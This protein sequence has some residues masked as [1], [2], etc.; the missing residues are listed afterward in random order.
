MGS[1][2]YVVLPRK[3][4]HNSTEHLSL[5]QSLHHGCMVWTGLF[6]QFFFCLSWSLRV[7]KTTVQLTLSSSTQQ[8]HS[9]IGL[10]FRIPQC[11]IPGRGPCW[12][13]FLPEF[14]AWIRLC[15]NCD[16]SSLSEKRCLAF[17]HSFFLDITMKYKKYFEGSYRILWK[18]LGRRRGANKVT[19][20]K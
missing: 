13:W 19:S 2:S 8:G 1:D 16:I 9:G 17:S 11:H 12:V 14:C 5:I 20:K 18:E 10:L 7:W 4:K 6:Q 15:L 3:H